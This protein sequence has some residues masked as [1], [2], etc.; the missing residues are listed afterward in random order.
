MIDTVEVICTQIFEKVSAFPY[1][2]RQFFK[3]LY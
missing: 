3:T 1:A 2:I